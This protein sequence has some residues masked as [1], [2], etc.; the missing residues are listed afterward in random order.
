MV[1]ITIIIITIIF[2]GR[3]GCETSEFIIFCHV[4]GN[5]ANAIYKRRQLTGVQVFILLLDLQKYLET[6]RFLNCFLSSG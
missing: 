1:I 5:T 6:P 2:S 4:G 3:G